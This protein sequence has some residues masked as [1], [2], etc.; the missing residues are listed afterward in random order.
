MNLRKSIETVG[1]TG[2]AWVEGLGSLGLLTGRGL[3]WR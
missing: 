2:V 3:A 1:A